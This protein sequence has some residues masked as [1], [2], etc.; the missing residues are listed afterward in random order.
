M[1]MQDKVDYVIIDEG[2]PLYVAPKHSVDIMIAWKKARMS[3]RGS[4]C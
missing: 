2:I 1:A 3:L 4:M